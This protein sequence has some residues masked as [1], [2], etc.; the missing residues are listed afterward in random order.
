MKSTEKHSP[1]LLFLQPSFFPLS[2]N[3]E[4]NQQ[5]YRRCE[6]VQAA[7]VILI[8]HKHAS[9][10]H[11]KQGLLS[12]ASRT[13][14]TESIEHARQRTTANMLAISVFC[15]CVSLTSGGGE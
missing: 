3:A 13:G 9:I 6:R 1:D 11:G 8:K 2:S 5:F 4:D 15:V 10:H 14:R 7:D 12:A